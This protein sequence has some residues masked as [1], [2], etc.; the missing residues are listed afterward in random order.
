MSNIA[1]YYDLTRIRPEVQAVLNRLN[2]MGPTF[3]ARAKGIDV[4][5]TFP[6]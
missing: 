6:V 4:D 3:A 2:E 5:A 1:D